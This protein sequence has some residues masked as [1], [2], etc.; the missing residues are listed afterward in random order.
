MQLKRADGRQAEDLRPVTI[1][2]RVQ[3]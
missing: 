3:R 1:Q 2:S